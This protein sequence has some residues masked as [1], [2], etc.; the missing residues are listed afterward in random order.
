MPYKDKEDKNQWQI[1]WRKKHK[2]MGLCHDCSRKSLFGLSLC[3]L[4]HEHLISYGKVW[5]DNHRKEIKKYHSMKR[6]QRIKEGK[7]IR[8]G[9]PLLDEEPKY[10]VNCMSRTSEESSLAQIK[11][12]LKYE[13]AE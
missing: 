4:H 7:C 1:G 5:R 2:E 3:L 6:T 11:G 9:A 13:T 12:V 10:C 8:C